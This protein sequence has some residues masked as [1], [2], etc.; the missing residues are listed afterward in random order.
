MEVGVGGF[1]GPPNADIND[2]TYLGSQ[3]S[4]IGQRIQDSY[5]WNDP[6]WPTVSNVEVIQVDLSL[7]SSP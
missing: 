6:F 2:R 7:S 4:E 5:L 3:D 1:G